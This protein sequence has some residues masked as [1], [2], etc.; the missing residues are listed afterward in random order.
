MVGHSAK[1][2]V[3]FRPN[4]CDLLGD[5]LSTTD[6]DSQTNVEQLLKRAADGD[7][8]ARSDLIDLYRGR[9]KNM[10]SLRMDRRLLSRLDASDILQEATIE[11][12]NR[13][14]DYFASSNSMDFFLWLR[15]I[16]NDKLIDA[17]RF[18]LGAQKRNIGMELSLDARPLAEATS[19]ALA[20][21]LL[22]RLDHPSEAIRM[23]ET[24]LALENA[25]NSLDGVDREVLVLRHFEGL[26]NKETSEILGLK[27]SGASKRYVNALS[28]LK[29]LLQSVPLFADYFPN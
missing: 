24:R 17:Q 11:A 27:K 1:L 6:S 16:A 20:E 18:H 5:E 2:D 13:M 12:S 28:A 7:Q 22:G 21:H 19:Y 23:A 9:I 29:E 26:S 10:V 14:D 3:S 15:W 8:T 4:P 25:I